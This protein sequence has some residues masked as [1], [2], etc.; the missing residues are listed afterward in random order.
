MALTWATGVRF[1]RATRRNDRESEAHLSTNAYNSL[2]HRSGPKTLISMRFLS[3][4]VFIAFGGLLFRSSFWPKCVLRPVF[5]LRCYLYGCNRRKLINFEIYEK[6]FFFPNS[7][8]CFLCKNPN[9]R[10]SLRI[11]EFWKNHSWY[12]V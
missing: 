9:F 2:G 5:N 11:N 7:L 3:F 6:S 4:Y 1:G 10:Y 8:V 12:S